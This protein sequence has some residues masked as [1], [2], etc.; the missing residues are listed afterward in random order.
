M[1]QGAWLR[2]ERSLYYR[3]R[4]MS[5]KI[6]VGIPSFLNEKLLQGFPAEAEIV[7]THGDSQDTSP[8]EVE[9]LLAPWSHRQVEQVLPCGW[10]SPLA[11]ALKGSCR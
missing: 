2:L 7:R 5:R 9:F 1:H 4:A 3:K 6:R 10:C 8:I 11:P